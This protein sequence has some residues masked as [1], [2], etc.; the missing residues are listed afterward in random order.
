M[1]KNSAMENVTI[2]GKVFRVALL[3]GTILLSGCAGMSVFSP[4]TWFSSPL[5]VS[6]AGVGEITSMTPMQMDV[7]N[8]QLDSRYKIRS[9]MQ[10]ENG[11]VVTIFQGIDDEQVKIEV[12]GP[13]NGYAAKIIVSDPN[14]VTQWGSGIGTSFADLYDKAFG[15]CKLGERINDLPT[16]E[17]VASQSPNV[18]YRFN[19]KWH[20][21]ENIM[22]SDDQL[23]E[24]QVSQIIWQK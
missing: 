8:Q 6:A 18:T 21:P 14:I 24:W 19:G 15:A 10:M 16:V 23:K 12:I 3:G 11:D 4:S 20:G 2:I 9:G 17:C 22:P 1:R 7:V 13:E 5:V